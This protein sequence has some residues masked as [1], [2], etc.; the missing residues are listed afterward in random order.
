MWCRGRCVDPILIAVFYY[1]NTRSGTR[2]LDDRTRKLVEEVK[3]LE[4]KVESQKKRVSIDFYAIVAEKADDSLLHN[5][6]LAR[7]HGSF[8]QAREV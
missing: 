4:Y 3:N 5:D 6:V 1:T 2:S 8:R 7:S